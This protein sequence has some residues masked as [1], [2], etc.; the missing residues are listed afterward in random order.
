MQVNM[1]LARFSLKNRESSRTVFEKFSFDARVLFLFSVAVDRC[2]N[3]GCS[4]TCKIVNEKAV[5]E[6]PRGYRPDPVNK[7]TCVG[8]QS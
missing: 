2:Q 4:H 3:A 5:C 6:C 8:K 7:K 1:W